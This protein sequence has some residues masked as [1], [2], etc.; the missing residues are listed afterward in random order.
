[1]VKPMSSLADGIRRL[2]RAIRRRVRAVRRLGPAGVLRRASRWPVNAYWQYRGTRTLSIGP[3]TA[4]FHTEY[5]DEIR[6]IRFLLAHERTVIEDLLAELRPGDVFYDVGANI[7]VHACLAGSTGADVIAFEPYPPNVRRLRENVEL[8][9]QG[10]HVDIQHVALADEPGVAAFDSGAVNSPGWP[11]A[12]LGSAEETVE[13]RQA[14]GDQLV[15]EKTVPP[16]TVVK[17]D[18]EGAEPLVIDGLAETLAN[19]DCRLVYCEVHR[20]GTVHPS[21]NDFGQTVGGV[22]DQLESLGFTVERFDD[23]AHEAYLKAH[24]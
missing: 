23:R 14:T 1:M 4:T 15:G 18:V 2:D 24:R 8:N 6:V 22:T 5:P 20:D 7:G 19:G 9:E 11:W 13:V 21:A 3:E 12:S 17:I 10:E 16:P